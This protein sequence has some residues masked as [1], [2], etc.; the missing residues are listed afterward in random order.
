MS[1]IWPG[2][3]VALSNVYLLP[4]RFQVRQSNDSDNTD[5]EHI[6]QIIDTDSEQ[7]NFLLA[8]YTGW[9]GLLTGLCTGGA[10]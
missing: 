5:T 1:G 9:L 6:I 2:V 3:V 7:S 4:V 8:L 10:V